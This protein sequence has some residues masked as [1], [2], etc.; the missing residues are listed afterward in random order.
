MCIV[1]GIDLSAF[2]KPES[3]RAFHQSHCSDL[4]ATPGVYVVLRQALAIPSFLPASKA[5]WFKGNDPSYPIDTVKENWVEGAKVLYVGKAEGRVGLRAQVR[6]L[7]NIAYGKK[8]GHR[9]GRMLWHLSD[10]EDLQ[11]VWRTCDDGG[12]GRLESELID[13]FRRVHQVRPFAN[14]IK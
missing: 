7:V 13:S 12:A 9:G 14:M 8:I 11:V 4:P 10:W 1:D 2:F 3:I 5:G 6:Q